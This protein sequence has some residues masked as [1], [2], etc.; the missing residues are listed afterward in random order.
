LRQ[1]SS[2]YPSPD[3]PGL[4]KYY[5]RAC[6]RAPESA[7]RDVNRTTAEFLDGY[8]AQYPEEAYQ[9][10]YPNAPSDRYA[11]VPGQATSYLLGSR[12]I[13]RLRALAERNLG[14]DFDIRVFYDRILEN[15]AVT[16]LMLSMRIEAWIDE[17]L[18]A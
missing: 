4:K 12:E 5:C 13:Q 8:F 6:H 10:G 2:T 11:T 3:P 18:A 7:T 14:D 16:L 17:T 9:S 1:R 15:G